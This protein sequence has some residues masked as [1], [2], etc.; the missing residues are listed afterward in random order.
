V[1][2]DF[3]Q[4]VL[5]SILIAIPLG[6]YFANSWLETYAFQTNLSWWIFAGSGVLLLL[7]ALGTVG[8]Q[9]Y[10]A[11]SANPVNSLRSE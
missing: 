8:F 6:W 7:I 11:A 5:I 3:V 1:S 4:L 10:K 9:A 2:K